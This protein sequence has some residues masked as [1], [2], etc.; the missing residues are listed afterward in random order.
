[1]KLGKTQELFIARAVGGIVER[2][3]AFIGR[4]K[5]NYR[6][7]ITRSAVNSFLLNLTA[8]YDCVYAVALGADSL[9]LGTISS[10]GNGFSAVISVPIGWLVDRHGV[11]RLYLLGMGLLAGVALLYALA[12]NWQAIIAAAIL[13]SISMRLT[14]TG[15]SVI[16]ADSVQNED[17]ATAQNMCITFASLLSLIAPLI[18]APLITACGGLTAQ[19]IRP[20]YYVR[21]VGHGLL[22]LGMAAQLAEPERMRASGPEANPGFLGGFRQLL[23]GEV[24]LGRWLVISSL[25]WLPMA[26]TAPFMQLFAHQAKGADQYLLGIMTTAAILGRVLFGIPLGRL[27]DLIGRKKAIYLV[28][29]LWYASNLALVLSFNAATLILAGALQTF[30]AISAGITGAMTLELVPVEQMGKWSGL[31]GLLRGLVTIPAP[32]LGGLVWKS[33]GPVYVFLIPIAID[34]LLRMPLLTTM[35]E[36]LRTRAPSGEKGQRCLGRA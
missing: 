3:L 1:L 27:A 14:G 7:A 17:R 21:F 35:P 26:M 22:L 10:I 34:L 31:L 23:Q 11:R 12:P 28:T 8:Q 20:L 9:G 32:I 24:L 5:H 30:Y 25:T 36:T 33:I 4:Q 15:C 29:P 2:V 16:C 6:V 18:A 13:F 19:G